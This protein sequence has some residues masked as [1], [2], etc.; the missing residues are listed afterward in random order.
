M[1]DYDGRLISFNYPRQDGN[2]KVIKVKVER[3][4]RDTAGETKSNRGSPFARVLSKFSIEVSFPVE[5]IR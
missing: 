5:L 4:S 3:A 1:N 2:Y